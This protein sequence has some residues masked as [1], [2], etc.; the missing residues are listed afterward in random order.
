MR[1]QRERRERPLTGKEACSASLGTTLF[2]ADWPLGSG[3]AARH[4]PAS[5]T[6]PRCRRI[7]ATG[8]RLSAQAAAHIPSSP[9]LLVR[10]VIVIRAGRDVRRNPRA[11]GKVLEARVIV[12]LRNRN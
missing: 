10:R 3:R 11:F 7:A 6:I 1:G 5:V 2:R 4:S 9:S 8:D 12:L